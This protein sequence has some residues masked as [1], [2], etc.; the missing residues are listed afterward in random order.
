M[1]NIILSALLTIIVI[2]CSTT[3]T[4]SDKYPASL[5]FSNEQME[6]I[7][8]ADTSKPLKVFKTTSKADSILLRS[9]STD[10]IA[11]SSDT[12]LNTLATRM[13]KTVTDSMSRG[14]GI[15]AP[16]VGILK[17]DNLGYSVLTKGISPL[18]SISILK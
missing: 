17:K 7:T 11:D 14:V 16:Q 2:G 1:K 8:S 13:Y 15:A 12:F 9:K 18:K 4:V 5:N 6:I 10:V 3:S